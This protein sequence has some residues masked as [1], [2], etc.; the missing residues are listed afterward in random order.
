MTQEP[1]P[2]EEDSA[3]NESER[4]PEI[5]V[6]VHTAGLRIVLE[7]RTLDV[8]NAYEREELSLDEC[9]ELVDDLRR[10]LEVYREHGV[11]NPGLP[12]EYPD[13]DENR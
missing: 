9:I 12:R 8:W 7:W 10:E 2:E 6:L 3:E 5:Y 4:P 13:G 1:P 11:G